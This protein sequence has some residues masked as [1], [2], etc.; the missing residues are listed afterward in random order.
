M[1]WIFLI[2]LLSGIL[3]VSYMLFGIF[4]F[5]FTVMLVINA[6]ETGNWVNYVWAI[7]TLGIAFGVLNINNDD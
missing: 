4:M 1:F 2:I 5:I 7:F 3:Y 6:N